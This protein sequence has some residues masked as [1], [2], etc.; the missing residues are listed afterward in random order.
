MGSNFTLGMAMKGADIKGLPRGKGTNVQ[1]FSS[2]F[3]NHIKRVRNF[4]RDH[5]SHGLIEVDIEDD[6]SG[7]YMESVFGIDQTCWR[8]SNINVK[9]HP[10]LDERR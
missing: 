1:D 8:H 5:P 3:C 2:F 9:L 6:A 7:S 10:E 4:V